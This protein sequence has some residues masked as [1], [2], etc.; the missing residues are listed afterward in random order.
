ML[1]G[2]RHYSTYSMHNTLQIL[3]KSRALIEQDSHFSQTHDRRYIVKN[4]KKQTSN[5]FREK[6]L[7]P[8]SFCGR[9]CLFIFHYMVDKKSVL[10]TLSCV[11][12][13]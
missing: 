5:D 4:L 2:L 1:L 7:Y 3:S 13:Q 10:M 11:Q 12:T 9:Y 8:Q 6:K